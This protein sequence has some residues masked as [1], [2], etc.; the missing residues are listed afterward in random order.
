MSKKT[1]K[2]RTYRKKRSTSKRKHSTSKKYRKH[3]RSNALAKG[4]TS[5]AV[6][7]CICGIKIRIEDGLVPAKCYTKNGAIRGHRICK[8]CWF[9]EFAKESDTHSCPGCV[10]GLPLNGPPIDTSVVV[11]LTADD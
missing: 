2:Y 9:N 11:D 5:D 1:S 8:K 4:A 7:C 10:K 3:R 6:N